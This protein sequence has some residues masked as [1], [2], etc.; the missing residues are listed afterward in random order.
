MKKMNL[1]MI[2]LML[3]TTLMIIGTASA[4]AQPTA[5]VEL[6]DEECD[7]TVWTYGNHNSITSGFESYFSSSVTGSTWT[8]A[9]GRLAVISENGYMTIN[10]ED[11]TDCF[12]I[13]FASDR[14]D[15]YAEVYVDDEKVWEGDTW[16]DVA[17]GQPIGAQKIRSL[18]ITDLQSTTHSIEIKNPNVNTVSNVHNGHVTIYKY[19]YD[20]PEDTEI[21]EF[22]TIALPVAAILGLAFVFHKREE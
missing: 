2:T 11:P 8:D 10:T 13:V 9:D 15:G 1:K 6:V 5:S 21:P 17:T 12:C 19:G 3:M 16:A 14:N 20:C 22:P 7:L 18:K 4:V